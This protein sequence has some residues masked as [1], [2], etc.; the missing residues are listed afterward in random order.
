MPGHHI[1]KRR[2]AG[3]VAVIATEAVRRSGLTTTGATLGDS[4]ALTFFGILDETTYVRV[5]EAVTHA[6][7]SGSRGL[8]IDVTAL[9]VPESSGWS[10][11]TEAR[12]TIV[13]E[14]D[15]SLVLVC[16]S[17]R[18]QNAL[19]RSRIDREIAVFWRFEDALA[20][21]PSGDDVAARVPR[22]ASDSSAQWLERWPTIPLKQS[23]HRRG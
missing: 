10:A 19:R 9:L 16:D 1:L 11:I 13:E 5:R 3:E 4:Q 21:L 18:G 15:I 22:P 23:G 17:I 20:A 2:R 8:I 7:L 6:A 14:S 12:K